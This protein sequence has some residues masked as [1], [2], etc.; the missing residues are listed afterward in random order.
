MQYAHCSYCGSAYPEDAPWPRVCSV[1]GEITWRNPLPVAVALLPVDTDEGRGL[2]VVRRDIE[3]GRGQLGLPGG[4]IEAGEQWRDA[5]VR[6]LRE[7]TTIE[8]SAADLTLFDVHS[9]PSGFTLLV[10]GL[11]PPRPASALPPSVATEEATGY[12]IIVKPQEL[13]FSTHTDAMASY[14][15]SLR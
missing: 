9:T 8:A 7:E 10:F 4:Y 2:V 12:E 1:C 11:L 6:E 3:P 13:V 5:A 15:A 14:F